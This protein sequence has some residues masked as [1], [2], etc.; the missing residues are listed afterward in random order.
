MKKVILTVF[1]TV[2]TA[3]AFAQS[4]TNSPYSMFGLGTLAEQ[5]TGFNRGM[6]GVGIAMSEGNGINVLNP[7][8]YSKVDS[9]SF[10]FDVAMSLQ[11][12][13][14]KEKGVKMNA[15]NSDMEY[16]VGSFRLA[17]NFGL[18]FGILPYTNVG[19]NFSTSKEMEN[20]KPS[21]S[22]IYSTT[23]AYNGSG[24]LHQAFVGLGYSPLKNFSFGVNFN[25]LWGSYTR[26]VVNSYT[27]AGAK[28]LSKIYSVDVN[29]VKLQLGAQYDL[30]LSKKDKLTLG[31]TYTFGHVVEDNPA[32]DIYSASSSTSV[33]DTIH[34]EA[35]DA[36]EIPSE[37][38]IG[39]AYNHSGKWIVGLDYTYQNWGDVVSPTLTTSSEGYSY[40]A[41]KGLYTNRHKVNLGF[42]Y[43]QD[44]QSRSFLP[45]IRYRG[46]ISYTTP[47]LNI[48]TIN[49]TTGK[50]VMYKG[51][52][53][54]AATIGLGIPVTNTWNNR[55]ILNISAQWVHLGQK[56]LITENT[57]RITVGLTFNERWFA[58]WKFD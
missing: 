2:F 11:V 19:Y 47:Y 50:S 21:G 30:K 58:K 49:Q 15:N 33:A 34:L 54:I 1:S 22:T 27:D 25:Y 24:G 14:F 20:Y 31:A 45:R 4:G 39:V 38:G 42:Q 18:G 7:A 13:N 36:I 46:G 32:L 44:Q 9:L 8:S 12:T 23:N 41:R 29:N 40:V 37:L 55:S 35:K 52:G 43:C 26:N 48:N 57:F 56:D 10:I 28:S 3:V 17:K 6:N 5:S 51:P 16:A 53:E